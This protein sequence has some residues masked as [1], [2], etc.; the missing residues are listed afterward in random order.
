MRRFTMEN[1]EGYTQRQLDVLNA[2]YDVALDAW[3]ASLAPEKSFTNEDLCSHF[4]HI[5]ERVQ[6]DYDTKISAPAITAGWAE[7]NN[8]ST[9]FPVLMRCGHV[10]MRR[11][12]P[13]TARAT[14]SPDGE[15][16]SGNLCAACFAQHNEHAIARYSAA[17]KL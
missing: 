15:I 3:D 12:K 8:L 7:P 10:E 4:D 2:R 13:S 9:S 5:A 11:M 17:G 6:A 16:R 1:T 14:A